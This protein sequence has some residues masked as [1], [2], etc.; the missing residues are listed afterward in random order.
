VGLQPVERLDHQK[1]LLVLS[2][3]PKGPAA[4]AGVLIGDILVTLGGKA[5]S[6]TDDIQAALE[7]HAVGSAID[8]GV[9]RGGALRNIAITV[10][11]RPHKD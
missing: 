1:G 9:S 3:E 8:A 7:G 6:D 10:G 5:T 11:E 2:L 4:S